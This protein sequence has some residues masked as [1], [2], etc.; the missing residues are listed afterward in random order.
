MLSTATE[1]VT[2]TTDLEIRLASNIQKGVE[3]HAGQRQPVRL[4]LTVLRKS[5]VLLMIP[6]KLNQKLL[7]VGLITQ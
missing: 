2:V 7:R 4:E 1:T 3:R 6:A 5:T